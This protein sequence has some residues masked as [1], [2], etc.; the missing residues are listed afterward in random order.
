MNSGPLDAVLDA[1]KNAAR[2]DNVV[3]RRGARITP[4]GNCSRA[5][6][7]IRVCAPAIKITYAARQRDAKIA[8]ALSRCASTGRGLRIDEGLRSSIV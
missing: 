5:Y 7:Y 2:G 3:A 6:I 4:R 1:R 8:L